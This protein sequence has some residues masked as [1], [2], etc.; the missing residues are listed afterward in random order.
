[1]N[2]EFQIPE[3]NEVFADLLNE[4]M[5]EK[6]LVGSV[7]KGTIVK[8]TPDFV[9][10]DVGLKSEGRIP[11]REFGQNPELKIGDVIEVYVDRYEDREGN[12]V[13]SREKARREEAWQDLE[14][15]MNAG[16]RINGVITPHAHINRIFFGR[17][18]DGRRIAGQE[19]CF[20]QSDLTR[21]D[22]SKKVST[23]NNRKMTYTKDAREIC[24]DV[25]EAHNINISREPLPTG[26]KK[27]KELDAYITQQNRRKKKETEEA[28]KRAEE[29][30]KKAEEAE[31]KAVMEIIKMGRDCGGT[32]EFVTKRLC[33]K[34]GFDE[35]EA[36]GKVDL[37]WE[38]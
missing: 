19:D 3:T 2:T 26:N 16:E 12:I 20:N 24:L 9:M 18:K 13:L 5:G 30:E 35:K 28:E 22:E 27:H 6:S 11:V 36:K 32:K 15:A 23:Y 31:K 25:C 8:I 29:A 4:Q 34:Y 14:K 21:P 38:N 1:M 10:V 17:D 7:V 33:D 37:Y